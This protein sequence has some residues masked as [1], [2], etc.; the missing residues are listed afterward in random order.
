VQD[1]HGLGNLSGHRHQ[2]L[3]GEE[4]NKVRELLEGSERQ[5]RG[6]VDDRITRVVPAAASKPRSFSV[7][8]STSSAADSP[9][10]NQL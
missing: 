3:K 2:I 10:T 6:C 4:M 8:G 5:G 1:R 9:D 7:E